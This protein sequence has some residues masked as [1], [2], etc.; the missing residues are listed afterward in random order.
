MP[1]YSPANQHPAGSPLWWMSRLLPKLDEQ[2]KR[3]KALESLI[4]DGYD[5]LPKP[6]SA[7]AND[8]RWAEALE[9]FKTL[10]KMGVTNL[11]PM[12]ARAPSDR[13][14][15]TGFRF[16]ELTTPTRDQVLWPMWQRNHLKADS[17]LA[18]DTALQCGNCYTL[19]WPDSDGKATI[20]I[21]HPSEM[22]VAYVA[23]D[24]RARAAALKRWVDDSGRVMVTVYLPS[25]IYKYQS[26]ST[27]N[28]I[29]A[30]G[31]NN[32]EER[33]V[34]G[35]DWPIPNPWGKVT[36]VELAVNTTLRPRPF[37][38]GR[39]EIA[40]PA[41][42]IQARI[43]KGVC[44]RLHIQENHAY[45]QRWVA[46]W[47]PEKPEDEMKVGAARMLTFSNKDTKVGQW[48]PADLTGLF[49]GL[50]SDVALLA[51]STFTPQSYMPL[52][53]KNL[54]AETIAQT[55]L[56]YVS[57][58]K[59]HVDHIGEGFDE[60]L[61]LGLEIERDQRWQDPA[62]QVLWAD[63]ELH[64]LG[65]AVDAG[66]KKKS[67]GIPLEEIWASLPGVTQDDVDRWKAMSAAGAF[68]AGADLEAAAAP[69]PAV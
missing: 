27:S 48:D 40:G 12:V 56:G 19:V 13:M 7:M 65:E 8:A 45:P 41:R 61:R 2:A 58:T 63:V 34:V 18:I 62:G 24:R 31:V 22:I 44:D 57:K 59:R 36:V 54:G 28:Y 10:S 55:N 37:G 69:G 50:E 60:T 66:T 30:L 49:A 39:A 26:K 67:L 9:A 21:E 16:G 14:A 68:L 25:G 6:P 42:P 33:H 3:V 17:R 43:N 15:V 20:T 5:E 11:L 52:D 47:K 32:W 64:T 29:H 46:G 38:G 51:V 53:L 35:E 23:G 1:D 4:D